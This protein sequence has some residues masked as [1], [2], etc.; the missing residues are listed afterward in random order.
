MS[1]AT[2]NKLLENLTQTSAYNQNKI[3]N[4]ANNY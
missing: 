1:E 3:R 2:E 4:F